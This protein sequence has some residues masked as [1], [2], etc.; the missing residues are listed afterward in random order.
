MR[1]PVYISSCRVI[2][3]PRVLLSGI[4]ALPEENGLSAHKLYGNGNL[5]KFCKRALMLLSLLTVL[6][7]CRKA[8][9]VEPEV[10]KTSYEGT[11]VA[12][13]DSLTG[14]FGVTEDQAWPPRLEK[15]LLNNGYRYKVV[16]AG[17]IG[18]TSS[19]L[20]S[21]I[22]WILTLNPDIVVL[23]TGA[24]DGLRGINP[25][26]TRKNVEEAVRILKANKVTVVLAG[27]QIVQNLGKEYT[28]AFKSIYPA[29]AE[30]EGI[31]LIPFFLEGLAGNPQLNQPDGVHPT[32]EGYT[33]VL[34]NIY[35]YVIE[36]I[37]KSKADK[38]GFTP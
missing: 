22:K 35:P 9:Q 38:K 15:R 31:I 27:M 37:K 7:G 5:G 20:L 29:V 13:G 11:I 23:E 4:W 6:V 21:R 14:G 28:D 33:I 3:H 30:K 34:E 10:M 1:K 24:N 25:E 18:E 32:A 36:G 8:E 12:A 17:I 16:N 2:C 19:G 26:F